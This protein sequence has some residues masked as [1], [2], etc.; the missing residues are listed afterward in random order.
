MP[1][2]L[3]KHRFLLIIL[4]SVMIG[5]SIPCH[6]DC[7][8]SYNQSV[9]LLDSHLQKAQTAQKAATGNADAFEV[10]FRSS[11]AKLQEEKCLPELMSLIQRIQTEQQ[12]HPRPDKKAIPTPIVD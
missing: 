6:A 3:L 7:K 10:E 5:T 11:V 4:L 1:A 2:L 8:V 9:A 12:K